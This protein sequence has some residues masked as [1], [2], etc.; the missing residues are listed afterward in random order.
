VRPITSSHAKFELVFGERRYLAS[1]KAGIQTIRA[2]KRELSDEE[3]EDLQIMENLQRENLS[4]LD[5][6]AAFKRL[7][8]RRFRETQRHDDAVAF[9]VATVNKRPAYVVQRL[10]L[11]DLIPGAKD[12]VQQGKLLLGHASEL[13][14]LRTQEQVR[15]SDGWKKT[16]VIPGVPE[17]RLWIQQTLFLDPRN[18]PST[19]QTPT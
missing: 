13:A 1:Q 17:L 18:A 12:A 8:D 9:V 6:A 2:M 4:F 5:E 7:Y 16:H 15:T 11:N 10:K 14:R 3:A 19:P